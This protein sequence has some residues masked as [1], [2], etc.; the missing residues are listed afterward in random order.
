MVNGILNVYKEAGW[1]SNDVVA[2]L[3]GIVGQKKIG[4]TG[5]L[6]P[7]AEGVLPVCLG[8]ATKLCGALTDEKKTYEAVLLLGVSTDTQD[9]SGTVL[10]ERPADALDEETVRSVMASFLGRQ[11]QVPPMYS[12]RKVRGKRLYELARQ[13]IT[14]EREAR[15]V[16]FYD[17]TVLEMKLPRVRFQV[18]C[19][20]GTYIRT[21][22]AD[23]GGKLGCGGC[24]EKLLRTQVGPF[25]IDD[26]L[27]VGRLQELRDEGRLTD[28]LI[29]IDRMYAGL[30]PARTNRGGDRF[31]HNGNT[32]APAFFEERPPKDDRIRLYDSEGKFVGIF[33]K[34]GKSG[35]YQPEQMYYD[36]EE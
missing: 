33:R 20:R 29:P 8:R 28:A 9:V 11:M 25:R 7:D 16:W 21:L 32:V 31:A 5:T 35:S 13:G 14:V 6:D 24:M 26:A 18:T 34:T 36:P 4:H 19:S 27:K 23:V 1:T 15:P 30:A 22:C 17:I 12:A 10:D 2:K 3:K